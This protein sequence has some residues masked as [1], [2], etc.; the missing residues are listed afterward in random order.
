M[1]LNIIMTTLFLTNI[2]LILSYFY[3]IVVIS[4]LHYNF[5]SFSYAR[6]QKIQQ[7]AVRKCSLIFLASKSPKRGVSW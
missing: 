3:F 7:I 5:V 4:R 1:Q 6:P 2:S